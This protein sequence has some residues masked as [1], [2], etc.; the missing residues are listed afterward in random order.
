MRSFYLLMNDSQSAVALYKK[1]KAIEIKCTLAPT[2][3][4]ADACCGVAILYYNEN[5]KSKIMQIVNETKVKINKFYE[6]ENQNDPS[7]NK[8]C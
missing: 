3:R 4:S 2:P 1:L 7:R 8:F 5:D 6:C